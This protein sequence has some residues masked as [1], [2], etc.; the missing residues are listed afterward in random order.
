MRRTVLMAEEL[1]DVEDRLA[2]SANIQECL[3]ECVDSLTELNE[4]DGSR[5]D[6]TEANLRTMVERW[7]AELDLVKSETADELPKVD[8]RDATIS[9]ITAGVEDYRLD[10]AEF[11]NELCDHKV[12]LT[13]ELEKCRFTVDR[14]RAKVAAQNAPPVNWDRRPVTGDP[15][16]SKSDETLRN[17][18]NNYNVTASS[19][20][21]GHG[22][23]DDNPQ[24]QCSRST[25]EPR[26]C[27]ALIDESSFSYST[28]SVQPYLATSVDNIDDAFP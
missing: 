11:V 13:D 27:S 17:E 7:S 26:P 24:P 8:E 22:D 3:K 23:V 2:K 15:D 6:R 20:L 10:A 16:H 4:A 1:A 19:S 9:A 28:D 18:F 5:R 12:R 25:D 21:L 14:L